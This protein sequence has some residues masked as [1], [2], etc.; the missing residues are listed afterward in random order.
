MKKAKKH[1]SYRFES[2]I[3]RL[4]QKRET[5]QKTL[6]IGGVF[7]PNIVFYYKLVQ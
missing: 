5:T 1:K 6:K 2:K 4:A 3:A 7:L